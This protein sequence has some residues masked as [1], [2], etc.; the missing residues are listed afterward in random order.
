MLLAL[1]AS[2]FVTA[3]ETAPTAWA[4]VT[5]VMD[6]ELTTVWEVQGK[7]S[8]VTTDPLTKSVPV[9]VMVVPPAM[10]PASG[11]TEA[12]VGGSE[13]KNPA[14][15]ESIWLSGLVTVTVFEPA[16]VAAVVQVMVVAVVTGLAQA[17]PPISTVAPEMKSLP[18]IVMAVPPAV[19]P[20]VGAMDVIVGPA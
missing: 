9:I 10:A 13:N 7:L 15:T 18:V 3:R 5:Q 14:A 19:G 17:V 16:E 6:V 11:T 4:G 2:G 1:A 20:E 12:I 8:R